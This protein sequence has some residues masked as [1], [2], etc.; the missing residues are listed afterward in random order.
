M[1]YALSQAASRVRRLWSGCRVL[2]PLLLAGAASA[3]FATRFRYLPETLGDIDTV[4]FD[5]GVHDFYPFGHRPHPPG[6]AVFIGFAKLVHP[7]FDTHA[8]GLAFPSVLFSAVV[9]LPLYVLSRQLVGRLPAA[10][11]CT[12]VIFNP[13][14]WLN[15]VRPMSDLMGFTAVLTAQCL[16]V[17]AL[18]S[19]TESGERRRLIW[20]LGVIVAGL[21]VGVRVQAAVLVGPILALGFLQHRHL[22]LPAIVLLPATCALWIVPTVVASGGL[23]RFLARQGQVVSNALPVEPLVTRITWERMYGGAMDALVLPWGRPWLGGVM[24]L[25][26]AAGAAVLWRYQRRSLGLILLL[27][28]PYALYHYLLQATNLRYAIPILP[29]VALLAAAAAGRAVR[30]RTPG[31]V[32]IASAFLI[33][34]V[35]ITRPALE[36]YAGEPT[37]P[38]SAVRY[39]RDLAGSDQAPVVAGH[40]VFERYLTELA[41]IARVIR[42][43]PNEE[44]RA[45]NR[46]WV[47]GGREPVWFVRDPARIMLRR[48]A[49]PS[50]QTRVASWKWPDPVARLLKGARPTKA[51]LVRM[52]PPRWFAE[53]GFFLTP[54][55]GAADRVAREQHLLFV[56]SDASSADVVVSGTALSAAAVKVVVGEEVQSAWQVDNYFSL[57]VVVPSGPS[58]VYVPVRF[59]ASAPLLLTDVSL[60]ADGAERLRP[61]AGFYAPEQDE[62]D[63]AFRWMGPR[64]EAVV[65]RSG[66]PLRVTLRA[67]VPVEHFRM[68]FTLHVKV[69]GAPGRDYEVDAG[70]FVV[71]L[72]LPPSEPRSSTAVTFSTSQSF[73][74]DETER[75]GD[76]RALAIRVYDLQTERR[77]PGIELNPAARHATLQPP[78]RLR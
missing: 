4:N 24:L 75:N 60:A 58:D 32:A 69:D 46:F 43:R 51:E 5:L 61:L 52:D 37:P 57:Q 3:I 17:R 28:G 27:F 76:R 65:S 23:Q 30:G 8:A 77:S 42:T 35:R 26:A 20:C 34:S 15:S 47:A 71:E 44:W 2:E 41:P 16:L 62:L 38:A 55:A 70:D 49:D 72:D 14:F 21:A 48:L 33:V 56:R 19:A 10:L 63:Q 36:A 18:M 67:S 53:S 66:A 1:L 6:Y 12:L 13:V 73:V 59:E 40:H 11:A 54:E 50:A 22:R 64:G 45:L 29:L 7:L 25:A 78:S 39:L 31:M 68:P 9:V 74:P